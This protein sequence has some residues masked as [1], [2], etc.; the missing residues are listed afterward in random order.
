MRVRGAR[1][2]DCRVRPLAV[3][4]ACSALLAGCGG[5]S[6]A[7][8]AATAGASGRAGCAELE[9]KVRAVSRLMTASA[10]LVTESLHPEAL[11][12][13]TGETERNL[14]YA[15]GVVAA[16]PTAPSLEPAH[17][18]FVAGLRRFAADFGRARRSVQQ[19]DIAG[20]AEELS[21]AAALAQLKRATTRIDRICRV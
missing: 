9:S 14:R 18:Q 8:P 1:S 20:A 5:E 4:L 7:P 15:A 16:V 10:D 17:R 2:H 19:G 12:R 13:R 21:D 11:A 6:S 3:A